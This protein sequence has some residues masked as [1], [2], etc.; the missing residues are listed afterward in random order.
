M[1]AMPQP[2][3][4]VTGMTLSASDEV[5][6]LLQPDYNVLSVAV[7]SVLAHAQE[8]V[9]ALVILTFDAPLTT[10]PLDHRLRSLSLALQH[11]TPAPVMLALLPSDTSDEALQTLADAGIDDCLFAP[12]RVRVLHQRVANLLHQWALTL[13]NE[14]LERRWQQAFSRTH[15]VMLLIDSTNGA[16]VEANRAASRF[17]GYKPEAFARLT[18]HDLDVETPENDARRPNT[19]FTFRHKMKSGELRDVKM[20]TA[21]IDVNGRALL[22]AIVFDNSRRVRAEVAES[23]Q[24]A[25][26]EALRQTSAAISSTLDLDEVLERILERLSEVVRHDSANIMLID[27][28]TARIVRSRG[29]ERWTDPAILNAIRLPVAKTRNLRWMMDHRQPHYIPDVR[30]YEGWTPADDARWIR[31]HLS[32]PILIGHRV[33]GFLNLDNAA[34]GQ[35]TERDAERLQAF[36]DQAAIAIRNAR[37]YHRVRQQAEEL[38][39]R[40]TE[41][42]AELESER[43]QLRAILDAMTEGVAYTTF[44]EGKLHT[45]YINAALTN[46]L[47]YDAEA[48]KTH[49][50]NL[51]LRPDTTQ[52]E[53]EALLAE[54]NSTLSRQHTWRAEGR[55]PRQD[56]VFVDIATTT[57]AVNDQ[58][59]EQ[60]GTL[61]VIRDVSQEKALESQKTRFVAYASHELRTPITNLKTRLYLMRKQP[62]RLEQH[63]AVLE[64]VTDRMRRLI[65]GL[66]DLSRFERGIIQLER[67]TTPLQVVL[68]KTAEVQAMEAERK[69][70]TFQVDMPDT[71]IFA[72][73]DVDR[74]VQVVTNFVTNAIT[75][76]DEGGQVILRLHPAAPS[77]PS[78]ALVEVCDTGVGIAS[79][80]LPHLFQPFYRAESQM[81]GTGLGLNISK[82]IVELHGGRV[83]V[84]STLGKGSCFYFT[85]PITSPPSD[86]VADVEE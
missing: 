24:R 71:P 3:I 19:L 7:G 40:V 9:P 16:I 83:G 28:G 34:P 73:I 66:L 75:Y 54:V 13:H 22:F 2:R 55:V 60:V 63:I 38:E 46:I 62:E 20:F 81:E 45:Q 65:E 61:T 32:A 67:Q 50:I 12:L 25:M 39:Q 23:E 11:L 37:L 76:T 26:A 27:G 4:L 57:T 5:A 52:E 15:A 85:L 31:G 30:E 77:E 36:A 43:G 53:Y 64:T 42:T 48:W 14:R 86:A 74:M 79:E 70:L 56:G 78:V 47:G 59:G 29:Y 6:L 80:H 41:R 51:L 10:L 72:Y 17:Y 33:I 1:N 18:I 69:G 21:P 58:Q 44:E 8:E 84:E 82:E 49:S 35:F 68:E